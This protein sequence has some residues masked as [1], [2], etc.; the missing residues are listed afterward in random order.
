M[1]EPVEQR[2]SQAR[3]RSLTTTRNFPVPFFLSSQPSGLYLLALHKQWLVIGWE[4]IKSPNKYRTLE[5]CQCMA[6]T[7][8]CCSSVSIVQVQQ[9][10]QLGRSPIGLRRCARFFATLQDATRGQSVPT[11]PCFH[12][13]PLV[14]KSPHSD[15]LNLRHHHELACNL[16]VIVL[17][18]PFHLLRRRCKTTTC[19][20][21]DATFRPNLRLS[22][23]ER[24]SHRLLCILHYFS[25]LIILFST[26]RTQRRLQ[27]AT[28]YRLRPPDSRK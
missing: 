5:A 13:F 2:T 22:H 1:T 12:C 27:K 24:S 17:V 18:I 23:H 19:I 16:V 6:F 14:F 10:T 15:I 7:Y 20:P 4:N 25:T 28:N 26:H 11:R 9:L 8:P 3:C 21:D